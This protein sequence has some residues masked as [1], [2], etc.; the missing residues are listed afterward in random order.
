MKEIIYIFMG[1]SVSIG[2]VVYIA[3]SLPKP[4]PIPCDQMEDYQVWQL[5]VRC[6]DYWEQRKK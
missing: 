4:A 6:I 5:P 2:L 3:L 1:V